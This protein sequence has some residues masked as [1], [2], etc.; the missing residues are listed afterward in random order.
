MAQKSSSKNVRKST[1]DLFDS[2]NDSRFKTMY[3]QAFVDHSKRESRDQTNT[4]IYPMNRLSNQLAP[5]MTTPA[6]H[7]AKHV[8]D[9]SPSEAAYTNMS[10]DNRRYVLIYVLL[11]RLTIWCYAKN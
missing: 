5:K 10:A 4:M 6:K 11:F 8:F 3:S 9:R 1:N 2:G 7:S